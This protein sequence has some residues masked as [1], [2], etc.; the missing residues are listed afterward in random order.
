MTA[1][2]ST[3]LTQSVDAGAVA[4]TAS[5]A[6]TYTLSTPTTVTQA[7]APNGYIFAGLQQTGTANSAASVSVAAAID[8]LQ[9]AVFTNAPFAL[10]FSVAATTATAPATLVSSTTVTVTPL[11]WLVWLA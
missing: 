3:L 2:T 11:V 5:Q 7:N 9:A 6:N 10:T 1:A 8:V 4:P